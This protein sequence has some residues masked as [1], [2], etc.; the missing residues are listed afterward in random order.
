MD[1]GVCSAVYS[2]LP[3]E[4]ALD[5]FAPLG[6][7]SVEIFSGGSGV[8]SHIDAPALLASGKALADYEDIF[9]RRGMRIGSLNATANPVHPVKEIRDVAHEGFVRTVKLAEKMHIDTVVVFSGTPG[10]KPRGS[11]AELDHLPLAG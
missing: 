4:E 6:I 10:G 11:D 3:I 2:E 7:K 1:L 8:N 5:R 9:K